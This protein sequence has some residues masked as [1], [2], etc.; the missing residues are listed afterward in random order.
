MRDALLMCI[1]ACIGFTVAS[2][3]MIAIMK[4]RFAEFENRIDYLQRIM[5][6]HSNR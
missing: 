6:E 4:A 5:D 3:V 2:M 1:G